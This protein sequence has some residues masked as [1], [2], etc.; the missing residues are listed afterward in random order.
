MTYPYVV[1]KILSHYPDIDPGAISHRLRHSSFVNVSKKYLYFEVPK[2]ACTQMKELLRQQEGAPPIQIF[3]GK[4]RETRREMFIHARENVPLPSLVD[5]DEAT[6]REVLESDSFFRFAIVRNPYTRLVSAWKNKVVPCEPGAERVYLAIKGRL[7]DM[8]AKE[9][10]AFDE[11]VGYLQSK[12]DLSEF[13]PHWRRQVD[14]LFLNALSF[15]HVGKVED[16]AASMTRLQ[17]HLGLAEALMGGKKN[18]SAPV[19]LATYDQDL[20]DKVYSIYREDFER[21]GY[22][23]DSWRDGQ[24]AVPAPPKAVIPEA[25]FYDEII[26]RNLIISGLYAERE[27]LRA[28]LKRV[29]RLHLMPLVNAVASLR[30]RAVALASKIRGGGAKDAGK[31]KRAPVKDVKVL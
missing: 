24:S 25:R 22:G 12:S 28:D 10:I 23:R 3:A 17:Q 14:H 8:H 30:R 19:G 6:Q 11:F 13:D 7:P 1:R 29:S 26:E 5:L 4:L 16:M 18:V 31:R 21:L 20:A 15:S 27:R 2:A 9:L